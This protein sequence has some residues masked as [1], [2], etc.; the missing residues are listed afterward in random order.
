M[1]ETY[2][3]NTNIC[4]RLCYLHMIERKCTLKSSEYFWDISQLVVRCDFSRK[5]VVMLQMTIEIKSMLSWEKTYT[6]LN[7]LIKVVNNY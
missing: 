1:A 2:L 7:G 5:L 3:D 4:L 6:I